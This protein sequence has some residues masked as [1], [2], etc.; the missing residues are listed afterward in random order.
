MH[1][2]YRKAVL[3]ELDRVLASDAT[4][5]QLWGSATRDPRDVMEDEA[6]SERRWRLR[7]LFLGYRH[8]PSAS[9]WLTDEEISQATVHA[10][11][12]DDKYVHAGQL[13]P[14]EQRPL[15]PNTFTHKERRTYDYR[16]NYSRRAHS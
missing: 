16:I 12:T 15:V 14:W 7:H 3:A 4:V 8:G 13:D 2:P 11:G 10:W 6:L 9:Q 5:L 1:S